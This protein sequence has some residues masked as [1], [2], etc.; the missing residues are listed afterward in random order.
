MDIVSL[1]GATALSSLTSMKSSDPGSFNRLDGIFAVALWDE[2]SRT[3][4]LARDPIGVKPLYIYRHGGELR[5]AS[6][7]KALL[8]DAA[9]PRHLDLTALDHHLTYRLTPAPRTLLKGIEKLEPRF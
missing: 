9:V 3:L 2:R 7:I 1:P 6:E 5:F 8:E 4:L